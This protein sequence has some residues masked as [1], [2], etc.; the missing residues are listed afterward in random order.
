M[1]KRLQL[2]FA[3]L[4]QTL[5]KLFLEV[6]GFFYLALGGIILLSSYSQIQE[7]LNFG[8]VSY[9]KLG[10]TLIFGLLL[11][12]YGLQSFYRVRRMK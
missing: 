5:H 6:T 3:G 8:E 7:Y 2:A 10:S 12:F 9:F 11:C 4:I 1:L